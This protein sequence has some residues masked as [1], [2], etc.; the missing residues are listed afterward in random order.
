MNI[1]YSGYL[2]STV[3]GIVS[4]TDDIFAVA[5]AANTVAESTLVTCLQRRS[6]VDVR[7]L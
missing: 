3:T 4:A 2:G 5:Y 7:S 1:A 6:P